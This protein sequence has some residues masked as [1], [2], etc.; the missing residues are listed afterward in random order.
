MDPSWEGRSWNSCEC[1]SALSLGMLGKLSYH[2]C[3]FLLFCL[4]YQESSFAVNFIG[5][6][7]VCA[8]GILSVDLETKSVP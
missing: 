6:I 5:S 1:L 4:T 8:L 3:V 7:S 2:E